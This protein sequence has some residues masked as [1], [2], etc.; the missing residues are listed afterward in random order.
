MPTLNISAVVD[1]SVLDGIVANLNPRTDE[2][3]QATCASAVTDIKGNIQAKHIIDTGNLYNSVD[4]EK[5]EKLLYRIFDGTE[6]GIYQELGTRRGIVARPFFIP[7]IEKNTQVLYEKIA[8]H[9]F[10]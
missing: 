1:T 3:L 8:E 2:A 6:Y 7:A 9:V 5:V 4:F 10:K